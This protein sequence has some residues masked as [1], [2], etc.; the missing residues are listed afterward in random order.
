MF[1]LN[2]WDNTRFYFFLTCEEVL[3]LQIEAL[4]VDTDISKNETVKGNVKDC[5]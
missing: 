2:I 3:Q 4:E 5:L 1:I